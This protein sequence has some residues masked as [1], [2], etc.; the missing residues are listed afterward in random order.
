MISQKISRDLQG[1]VNSSYVRECLG[2]D[3][4]DKKQVRENTTSKSRDSAHANDNKKVLLSITKEG[5]QEA[6]KEQAANADDKKQDS[7]LVDEY[8][9]TKGENEE[10]PLTSDNTNSTIF[11]ATLS[12]PPR[13]KDQLNQD[14]KEC[15]SCIDL[16][17]E[18]CELKEAVEKTT[19]L[20]TA[21][22]MSTTACSSPVDN[23]AAQS[24]ILEFEFH[25][26]RKDILDHM[27]SIDE[28]W[29]SGKIDNKSG[30]VISAR[31][32]R[33]SE[34]AEKMIEASC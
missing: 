33:L 23:K 26:R 24:G 29:F 18:N 30:H 5:A 20:I 28:V 21:D 19:Q 12:Q 15:S 22:K 8:E 27:G 14:L 32:G 16:Y 34:S 10:N 9:T 17:R 2:E 4:K 31:T 3:Y 1:R 25:L 6:I 11:A 7:A 13:L